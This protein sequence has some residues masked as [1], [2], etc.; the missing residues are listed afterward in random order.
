[1]ITI[2][3]KVNFYFLSH[4]ID[5]GKQDCFLTNTSN[6]LILSS[7]KSSKFHAENLRVQ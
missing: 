7:P 1:M 2:I 3:K 4:R 5:S 6:E